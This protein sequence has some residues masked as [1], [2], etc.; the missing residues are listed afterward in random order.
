[1]KLLSYISKIFSSIKE[2]FNINITKQGLV[3]NED[4]FADTLLKCDEKL[5][6]IENIT[7]E[8][9]IHYFWVAFKNNTLRDL[10]YL[11][12]ATTDK[13]PDVEDEE[14][15]EDNDLFNNISRDII[16]KYGRDLYNLFLLHA[17]GMTYEE[18]Y[19]ISNIENLK[20]KF[21]KIR[22]SIRGKYAK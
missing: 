11:R 6:N 16:T 13:I 17:N 2:K 20:Y 7:D 3:F 14:Y 12:N 9:M 4:I 1:M 19:N 10:K 5:S 15:T 8:E 21:R 22:E 18:L